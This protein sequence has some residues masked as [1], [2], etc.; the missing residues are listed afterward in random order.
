MIR[1]LESRDDEPRR[2]RAARWSIRARITI[3]LLAGIFAA[4]GLAM[5]ALTE[6]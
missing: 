4:L 5:G 1:S 3:M 2:S 6:K